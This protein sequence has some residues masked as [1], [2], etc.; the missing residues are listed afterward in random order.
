MDSR[1]GMAHELHDCVLGDVGPVAA[2]DE[3]DAGAVEAEVRQADALE[4]APPFLARHLRHFKGDLVSLGFQANEKA[5]GASGARGAVKSLLP[6]ACCP[7]AVVVLNELMP[8][9]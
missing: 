2:G 1:K 5:A 8:I 6:F 3:A 4:E 9:R 7:G